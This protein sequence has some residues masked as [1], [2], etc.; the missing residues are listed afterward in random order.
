MDAMKELEKQVERLLGELSEAR[1][2]NRNLAARVKK[3]EKA[4]GSA[5]DSKKLERERVELKRR[6]ERLVERLETLANE[7]Q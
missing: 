6:V 7:E 3:L 2:T 1:R 4:S 5:G